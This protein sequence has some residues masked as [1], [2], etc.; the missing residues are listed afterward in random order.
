MVHIQSEA[1]SF[2]VFWGPSVF[3]TFSLLRPPYPVKTRGATFPSKSTTDNA[4]TVGTTS[5]QNANKYQNLPP[6]IA[7]YRTGINIIC[8]IPKPNLPLSHRHFTRNCLTAPGSFS[9]SHSAAPGSFSPS[10]SAAPSSNSPFHS[11]APGSYSLG[12]FIFD[13]FSQN[14]SFRP[15][16]HYFIFLMKFGARYS[17]LKPIL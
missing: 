13:F 17:L 1:L 14:V 16:S 4:P 9:P 10:H 8:N 7:H 5:V 12:C 3:F 2:R 15:D 6:I 11:A